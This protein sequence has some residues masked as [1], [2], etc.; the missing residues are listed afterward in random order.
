MAVHHRDHQGIHAVEEVRSHHE[1]LVENGRSSDH[2]DRRSSLVE[3]AS[4]GG[5]HPHGA[6]CIHEGVLGG[7]SSSHPSVEEGSLRGV[8]AV[9]TW[10]DSAGWCC[11]ECQ[12]ESA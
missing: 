9:V 3:E 5:N 1:P 2:V 7:H 4:S 6:G 11:V 12:A 10:N 8:L